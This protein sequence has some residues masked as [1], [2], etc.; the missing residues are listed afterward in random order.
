MAYT[1]RAYSKTKKIFIYGSGTVLALL[2]F[3]AIYLPNYGITITTWDNQTIPDK[4]I[5]A[6]NSLDPCIQDIKI[7]T[8]EWALVAGKDLRVELNES[9]DVS[10][11]ITKRDS[12][13]RMRV[14]NLSKLN[15]PNETCVY[16]KINVTKPADKTVKWSLFSN[17]VVLDPVF[18][19]VIDYDKTT[20]TVSISNNQGKVAE[21]Q[22]VNL[23]QGVTNFDA[24]FRFLTYKKITLNNDDNYNWLSKVFTNISINTTVYMRNKV[25]VS[26]PNYGCKSYTELISVINGSPIQS[27]NETYVT[28]YYNVEYNA[29]SPLTFNK[30]TYE[31]NRNY[32]IIVKSNKKG[33]LG[34]FSADI[35][36]LIGGIDLEKYF[37][38]W[39]VSYLNKVMVQFSENIGVFRS[40]D[41]I[42]VNLTHNGNYGRD[43]SG[44]DVSNASDNGALFF[45]VTPSGTTQCIVRIKVENITANSNATI[46]YIYYNNNSK[47]TPRVLDLGHRNMYIFLD[48]FTDN[49]MYDNRTESGN[50]NWTRFSQS[51]ANTCNSG[52]CNLSITTATEYTISN[53]SNAPYTTWNNY[54][55]WVRWRTYSITGST[56][57]FFYRQY[58][59]KTYGGAASGWV[60]MDTYPASP[61]MRHLINNEAVNCGNSAYTLTLKT[62]QNAQ[63]LQLLNSSI[64]FRQNNTFIKDYGCGG[65]LDTNTLRKGTIHL[66]GYAEQVEVDAVWMYATENWNTLGG[67]IYQY[68][69]FQVITPLNRTYPT[70]NRSLYIS[71]TT[72]LTAT[73]FY[74]LNNQPNVSFTPNI[75]VT[76]LANI[77][78]NKIRIYSNTTD[79][80]FMQEMN[81]TVTEGTE[82][83]NLSSLQHSFTRESIVSR[84]DSISSVNPNKA[85]LFSYTADS[86]D[87]KYRLNLSSATTIQIDKDALGGAGINWSYISYWV[88]DFDTG[89][90]VVRGTTSISSGRDISLDI[91]GY[92]SFNPDRSVILVSS[93]EQDALTATCQFVFANMTNST[94]IHF[95]RGTTAC[96]GPTNIHWQLVEFKDNT[97]IQQKTVRTTGLTYLEVPI[98]PLKNL[99]RAFVI[100]NGNTTGNSFAVQLNLSRDYMKIHQASTGSY[101]IAFWIMEM[102]TAESNV[103]RYDYTLTGNVGQINTT[104]SQINLSRAVPFF[105]HKE[106]TINYATERVINFTSPTILQ[107]TILQ[108]DP[109]YTGTATTHIVDFY[110]NVEAPAPPADT[111]T[112]TA[113]QNWL[114]QCS[115]NCSIVGEVY[116]VK[117]ITYN[118]AGNITFTHSNITYDFENRA[119]Y[120]GV[121]K[122][123]DSIYAPRLRPT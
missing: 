94:R 56:T 3:F 58:T 10:V 77:G 7:C 33:N 118:G 30:Y 119:Q 22:L 35:S 93:S 44:I 98:E 106:D 18:E 42:V 47:I 8:H 99:S 16:L 15:I 53:N 113:N 88:A 61:T 59:N 13:G 75:N 12:L 9:K 117:N 114:I 80:L 64:H 90:N 43:C 1:K 115:D 68:A 11:K 29:D 19:S 65:S 109:A 76:F 41:L 110:S 85:V 34:L 54:T 52:A 26:Y 60:G 28:D 50:Y 72:G 121:W 48:N 89:V 14:Y 74:E 103:T 84:T 95:S 81:F 97:S 62:Y 100:M 87:L 57:G 102:D 6:G 78:A 122:S 21:L 66:M 69:D 55:S 67:T 107:T 25:N 27:C 123:L 86:Q 104:I 37:V 108:A 101:E 51:Y 31:A 116:D 83:I 32:T 39:N 96:N 82:N 20:K 49:N 17:Q 70:I 23:E 112:P 38:W 24:E 40:T 63:F 79:I 2:S 4:I 120:C 45:N 91:G 111:C 46:G 5:C 73:Y 92:G 105:I 71:S 36:P